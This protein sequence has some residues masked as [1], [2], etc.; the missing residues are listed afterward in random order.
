MLVLASIA[1]LFPQPSPVGPGKTNQRP[2]AFASAVAKS[3]CET[4]FHGGVWQKSGASKNRLRRP[5]KCSSTVAGAQHPWHYGNHFQQIGRRW[6]PGMH[7]VCSATFAGLIR[8]D[9]GGL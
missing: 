8:L 4:S 3:P 5:T 7:D 9:V 6:A 2:F 1:N